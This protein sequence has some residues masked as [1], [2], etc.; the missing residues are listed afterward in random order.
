[1]INTPIGDRTTEAAPEALGEFELE[2]SRA[3]R[4]GAEWA[5]EVLSAEGG[6]EAFAT[7]RPSATPLSSSA[8]DLIV[9]FE[10]SSEDVYERRYRSP[11]WPG[12]ASGVTVG[13][14]YDVGYATA[15]LLHS[16]WDNAIPAVTIK[17]LERG[18]GVK[19]P[20]AKPL[21]AALRTTV[22]IPFAPAI[23]VHRNKVLPRW[24]GIV[25][26]ALPNSSLLP[27]DSLGALV[28]LTYNRGASVRKDGDR[29]TEMRAIFDH[30]N[31]RAFG[32]IPGELRAMARLWPDVRGLQI[33]REREARL[34]ER[35]L[36]AS[37][38]T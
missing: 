36:A 26:D 18:L 1:M 25:E 31:R 2:Q 30:M 10:V 6:T 19:G 5:V 9:E 35:G 12:G 4:E 37:P 11:E 16:D 17:A 32:R 22:S 8:F 24:I 7:H 29:F 33:R 23:A 38:V 34:F 21:A 13:I 14:G 15:A 27:S 3:D 28:S 20:A